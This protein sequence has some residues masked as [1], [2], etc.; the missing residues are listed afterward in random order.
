MVGEQKLQQI[1]VMFT[2]LRMLCSH[3]FTLWEKYEKPN[4]EN[5]TSI[6]SPSFLDELR[7]ACKNEMNPNTPAACIVS[8]ILTMEKSVMMPTSPLKSPERFPKEDT[9]KASKI[10]Q[11]YREKMLQI[12]YSTYPDWDERRIRSHCPICQFPPHRGFI[13]SCN[14][15]YCEDC[16]DD[17][18]VRKED[19]RTCVIC[20]ASI[21]EFASSVPFDKTSHQTSTE[22]KRAN[23]FK[24]SKTPQNGKKRTKGF[25]NYVRVFHNTDDNRTNDTN[26]DEQS[27]NDQK[28]KS[29]ID[30]LGPQVPGTKLDRV[31]Q[32]I[33][34]W[35]KNDPSVKIVVFTLFLNTLKILKYIC[36]DELKILRNTSEDEE[37]EPLVVGMTPNS[38]FTILICL[39][40]QEKYL[41]TDATRLSTRLGRVKIRTS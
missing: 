15:V 4:Y 26:E 20:N 3:P 32:H 12:Y 40:S 28:T 18:A 24:D 22:K 41:W 11:S 35:I 10:I 36:K 23:A 38:W 39:R 7:K 33:R 31:R 13:T 25:K 34:D 17:P 27:S 19:V 30:A 5:G 21:E 14:H 37:C 29:W 9:A 2:N 8:S 1:F 6:L 16:F